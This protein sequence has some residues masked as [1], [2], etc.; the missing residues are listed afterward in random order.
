M[1]IER[2]KERHRSINNSRLGAWSTELEVTE[3]LPNRLF[4]RALSPT[5][6]G[7]RYVYVAN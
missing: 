4:L 7:R 3:V 5:M 1:E 6:L 2:E